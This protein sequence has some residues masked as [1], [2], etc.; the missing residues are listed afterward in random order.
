MLTT[1][2]GPSTKP[3]SA[4]V[5]T[6]INA[7]SVSSHNIGNQRRCVSQNSKAMIAAVPTT[8]PLMS[9]CMLLAISTTNTG[10]PV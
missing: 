2:I 6:R 4:S 3:P 8:D 9:R 7:S 5:A 10:R 1:L